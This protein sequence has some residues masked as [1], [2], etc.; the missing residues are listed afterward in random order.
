[1][2]VLPNLLEQ[3]GWAIVGLIVL[4]ILGLY[5]LRLVA[6]FRNGIFSKCWKQVTAGASFL[7]AAQIPLIASEIGQS[8]FNVGLVDAGAIMRLTGVVLIIIGLRSQTRIWRLE[9]IKYD[10]SKEEIPQEIDHSP[11]VR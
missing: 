5:C 11:R 1:M 10:K 2:V 7:I 9:G 8:S 3:N 4:S 6:I